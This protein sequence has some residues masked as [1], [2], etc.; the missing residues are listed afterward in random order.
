[1]L[2]CISS[3]YPNPKHPFCICI[4]KIFEFVSIFEL[5]YSKKYYQ[6]QMNI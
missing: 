2:S 1:M 6:N 4:K 3:K 5:K